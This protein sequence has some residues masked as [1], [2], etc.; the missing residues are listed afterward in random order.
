MRRIHTERI[1]I[2]EG[3]SSTTGRQ[4]SY[5]K[6]DKRRK[7]EASLPQGKRAAE[8]SIEAADGSR[9]CDDGRIRL[10]SVYDD[11]VCGE[12]E[13]DKYRRQLCGSIIPFR[14]YG[15]I[16]IGCGDRIY[17]GSDHH[18]CY[19][20]LSA[21]QAKQ[22]VFIQ[23]TGRMSYEIQKYFQKTFKPDTICSENL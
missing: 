7:A 10:L 17:D 8:R 13:S 15:R 22:V 19:I 5:G 6:T 3:I 14:Q 1:Y 20:F 2:S 18:R 23:I 12:T 16:C 11:P 9:L 21:K 4:T